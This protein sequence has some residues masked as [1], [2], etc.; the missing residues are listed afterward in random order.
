[1]RFDTLHASYSEREREIKEKEEENESSAEIF[2][3]GEKGDLLR[4]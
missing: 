2:L 4:D 3:I 1:M